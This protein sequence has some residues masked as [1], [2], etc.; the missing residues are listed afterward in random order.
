MNELNDDTSFSVLIRRRRNI[1]RLRQHQIGDALRVRPEAVGYWERGKR[2]IELDKLPRLAAI[3]QLN[4]K[5][6]CRTALRE[7]HPALY[8]ALFG[9]DQAPEP[10]SI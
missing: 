9:A 7:F 2:R 10:Q 4:E 8:H 1:L 5:D 3:L 6:V